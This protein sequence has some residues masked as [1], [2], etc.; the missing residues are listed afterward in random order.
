MT[1][2]WTPKRLGSQTIAAVQTEPGKPTSSQYITID[3][4]D[5]G[6][7]TGSA[8]PVACQGLL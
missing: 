1:T 8:D 2:K 4:R 6:K 3:V 7:S 5:G